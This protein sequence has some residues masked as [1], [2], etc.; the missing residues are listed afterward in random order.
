MAHHPHPWRPQPAPLGPPQD[1]CNSWRETPVFK[2]AER[3][4]DET[5]GM[6]RAQA[7]HRPWWGPGGAVS[8]GR[9]VPRILRLLLEAKAH[10]DSGL[11]C[12]EVSQEKSTYNGMTPLMIAAAKNSAQQLGLSGWSGGGS[13]S[14]HHRAVVE[15]KLGPYEIPGA[16]ALCCGRARRRTRPGAAAAADGH[17]LSSFSGRM[18]VN[19]RGATAL[20]LAAQNGH[21]ACVYSLLQAGAD[22]YKAG[23]VMGCC[24]SGL[25]LRMLEGAHLDVVKL[26]VES[27]RGEPSAA[28]LGQGGAVQRRHRALRGGP[29]GL[30]ASEKLGMAG[31]VP[32]VSALLK[33]S[34]LA[35]R[36]VS[37]RLVT[38]ADVN[39]ATAS[40]ETPLFVAS[41][42]NQDEVVKVLLARNADVN[43]AGSAE[44]ELSLFSWPL[45]V[46]ALATSQRPAGHAKVVR[47]LLEAGA[48]HAGTLSPSDPFS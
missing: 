2:A 3:N 39:A 6:P 30:R 38:G 29:E 33:G 24:G 31:L 47:Q 41:L 1:P 16:S 5:L 15:V 25:G 37:G 28:A 11:Q 27:R 43:K 14:F 19:D 45:S 48:D 20:F 10:K 9:V 12:L 26:L 8:V 34:H 21:R 13:G 40:N 23:C 22:R 4:H 17:F 18:Q 32:T 35:I 44:L 46:N 7:A 42:R 36:N